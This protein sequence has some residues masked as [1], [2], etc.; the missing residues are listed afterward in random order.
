MGK[1]IVCGAGI[2]GLAAAHWIQQHGH[3][4]LVLEKSARAGGV[5][6]TVEA[7]GYLF[8]KGPNSFL[9]NAPETLQLCREVHLE[10][11]LLKQSLRENKRYIYLNGRLHEVPS[12]P[13]AFFK[14]ELLTSSSK[15]G[16]LREAFR[17]SNRRPED[18][19]VADFTRRRLGDEILTHLLTPFISGV[20]AG[21]PEKLSLQA[22]FPLLFELEREY[23][24]LTLGMIGRMLRR[25]PKPN[26]KPRARNLCS[27]L[28]GMSELVGAIQNRLAQKVICRAETARIEKAGNGRYAVIT[29]SPEQTRVEC[30]AVVLALPAYAAAPLIQERMPRTSPY[31]ASVPYNRLTVTGMGYRRDQFS[32]APEG[33]GFLAP[34]GQGLRILGAIWNAS[35]FA[36][37]APG[38]ECGLTVFTGGGLDPEAYDLSDEALLAQVKEDLQRSMGAQG[39]PAN[40]QITRWEKAIPQYPV[41]HLGKIATLQEEA[42]QSPGLFLTGNYLDG[43]SVNDC[44]RNARR[45]ADKVNEYVSKAQGRTEP[46]T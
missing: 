38:G 17:K 24:S 41:G 27:F 16:L 29:R 9:D 32:E 33:F 40:Q 3:E 21:D 45:T 28:R 43:V 15:W 7:D 31:L 13:G 19:S 25:G 39:E 34:R 6:E 5:I 42:A 30:E 44:I 46:C 10:N 36:N 2:S 1:V 4:V 22:T 20:Y 23:G 37:R 35:L 18:E 12:G 8:E 26:S 11:R 14:T